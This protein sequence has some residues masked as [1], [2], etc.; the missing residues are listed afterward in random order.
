SYLRGRNAIASLF[1][2]KSVA[3]EAIV[4]Q[5]DLLMYGGSGIHTNAGGGIQ[6]LTPGG[7][8]TFGVEGAAPPSTAGVITRGQGD[9]QMYSRDSILLGQSRVMTTFGGD[10]LGWSAEGDI[11]AGRG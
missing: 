4:Y 8:Q 11:N 1:P 3:G 9:I 7:G 2:E 10:I 5:G 6:L